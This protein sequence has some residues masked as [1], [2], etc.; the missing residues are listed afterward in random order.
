MKITLDTCEVADKLMQDPYAGWS[1]AGAKAIAEYLEELEAD[2]GEEMEFDA[3]AIRCDFSEW[4]SL[5]V[6]ADDY[7]S[8]YKDK[9]GIDEDEEDEDTINEA[10]ENYIHD[11]GILIKFDD[12]II[13][14]NF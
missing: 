7:F 3:C 13:V 1:W 10:I 8:N 9:L 11:H 6:W 14:S 12:G 2:M 5:S 4:E